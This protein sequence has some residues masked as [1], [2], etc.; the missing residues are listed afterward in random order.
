MFLKRLFSSRHYER[1]VQLFR[2]PFWS[3]VWTSAALRLPLTLELR[4]GGTL[5]VSSAYGCRRMFDLLLNEL[6]D[7]FP[8]TVADGLV[9]FQYD[10][11]RFALRP[12]YADFTVFK[13]VIVRDNYQLGAFPYP[14]GT[15]VDLGA[16]IGLFTLKMATD[17]DRVVSVEPVR[18]NYEMA[19]RMLHRADL[20]HKVTLLKAVI[21][22]E[23]KGTVRIYAS[24]NNSGGHSVFHEHAA[25]WG[26]TRYED[27]PCMSLA[28]LFEREGIQGCSLLKC[29]VEGAEFDIIAAAPLELLASIDRILMEV[30]LNVINW[31]RQRLSE[32]L[33][34]LT[35]A[36][37]HIEHDSLVGRWG[38][39]KRGMMLSAIHQRATATRRA[40]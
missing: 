25:Q 19:Q 17:A 22:G 13:E 21:G 10:G 33:K 3:H 39:R 4:N 29:D 11:D 5:E 35:A 23:A 14:L 27:V 12:N 38:R 28:D 16:N 31:D 8:V 18:E 15:V 40:A 6:P 32:F 37:F 30:H 7:P 34:R 24:D 1:C 9:E 26:D 20:A 2:Q 36:G